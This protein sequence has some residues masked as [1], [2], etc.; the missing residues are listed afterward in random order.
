MSRTCDLCGGAAVYWAAWGHAW[1]ADHRPAARCA[2]GHSRARHL[3]GDGS[4]VCLL[5][6]CL[7]SGFELEGGAVTSGAATM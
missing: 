3:N 2:C 6:S 4:G 1:C 7:C 5:A